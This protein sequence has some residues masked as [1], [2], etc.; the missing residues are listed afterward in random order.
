MSE[1]I[2]EKKGCTIINN[3]YYGCCGNGG[4]N[5]P[6]GTVISYMGKKA[7]KHYL[8]CDGAIYNIADYKDFTQFL[9]DEYGSLDIF[10]GNGTT[11]FAVPDLR[12]EFLRGYHGDKAEKL[13]GEIGMH[14]EA[15]EMPGFYN[16]SYGAGIAIGLNSTDI[17]PGTDLNTASNADILNTGTYGYT[18]ITKN[19]EIRTSALPVRSFTSRPTNT[20]VLYCVKY[21]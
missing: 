7:P 5:T 4:D 9:K 17:T 8:A 12:N 3:Q 2:D 11:T 20:T 6:I 14:Q 13:S 16:N 19:G 1:C 10:G 18:Q 15:T 21:E